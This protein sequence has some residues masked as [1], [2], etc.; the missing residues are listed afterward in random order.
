MG[1]NI[2]HT[3]NS[4]QF[5]SRE[6]LRNAARNIL[7]KQGASQESVDRIINQ[8]VF[9]TNKYN[10]PQLNVLYSASQITLNNSLKETLKY[11]KTQANKKTKKE[12][13]LGE[14]W[15]FVNKEQIAY[16]G[17]LADFEIDSSAENIFAAA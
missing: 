6:N 4:F 13:I 1:L 12:P 15:D 7:N 14:L 17:E 3:M 10:S 11:I 9:Q 5:E 2:T 8:T 16:N